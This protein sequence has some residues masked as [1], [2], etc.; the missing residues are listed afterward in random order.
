ML[1][2]RVVAS[3]VTRCSSIWVPPTIKR[4]ELRTLI[5]R[6]WL[7]NLEASK[8][9]GQWMLIKGYNKMIVRRK[10]RRWHKPSNAATVMS[11]VTVSITQLT[12]YRWR[13]TWVIEEV[14]PYA[15]L[16][17][18]VA[19][20]TTE[21]VTTATSKRWRLCCRLHYL[22]SHEHNAIGR[23]RFLWGHECSRGGWLRCLWGC[24]KLSI[25][26]EEMSP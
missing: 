26:Q 21:V 12:L 1:Q 22:S 16:I 11:R 17:I 25:E 3:H 10:W 18:V 7:C 19:A 6:W 4:W 13:L 14:L 15:T 9:S 5:I 24:S 23:L 20:L 8:R 2:G